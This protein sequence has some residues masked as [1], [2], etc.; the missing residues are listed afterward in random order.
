MPKGLKEASTILWMAKK[1]ATMKHFKIFRTTSSLILF[2]FSISSYAEDQGYRWLPRDNES[3]YHY[4]YRRSDPEKRSGFNPGYWGQCGDLSGIQAQG[5]KLRSA[6][7]RGTNL[8]Q[9]NFSFADLS[10]AILDGADLEDADFSHAKLVSMQ[11]I[12]GLTWGA[13]FSNADLRNASFGGGNA[14]SRTKFDG[15]DLSG[16]TLRYGNFGS[17]SFVGITAVGTQFIGNAQTYANFKSANL[18]RASFQKSN[19]D[20]SNFIKANLKDTDFT[21]A[22]LYFVQGLENAHQSGANFCGAEKELPTP[23]YSMTFPCNN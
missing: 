10:H 13:N 11:M 21:R 12:D 14:F 19:L 3:E 9:A 2:I 1:G 17:S 4:C 20:N 22:R 6:D 7:L 8:K 16:A 15:A 5:K 18:E 23:P